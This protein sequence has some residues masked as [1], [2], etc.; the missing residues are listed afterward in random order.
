[1]KISQVMKDQVSFGS[2]NQSWPNTRSLH[3]A[4]VTIPSVRK[5]TAKKA[6]R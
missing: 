3:S 2:Q 5:H 1:M 6:A 4:P